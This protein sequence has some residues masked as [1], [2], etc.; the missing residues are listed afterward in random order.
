MKSRM[1]LSPLWKIRSWKKLFLCGKKSLENPTVELPS[2]IIE[3]KVLPRLHATVE[4][5]C[6][7]IESEL[8]RE[9]IEWEILPRLPAQSL[10]RFMRVCKQ[11]KSHI[12]TCDQFT[13]KY[14]QHINKEYLTHHKVL[15][16][17]NLSQTFSTRDCGDLNNHDS[18]IVPQEVLNLANLDGLV[19][20]E[21]VIIREYAFWN[22]LTGAYKKWSNSSKFDS[23]FVAFGLYFD[24]T[25][26]DYKV[27]QW[28]CFNGDFKALIYS[29][30]L[31]STKEIQ[32][33]ENH[34]RLS[35]SDWS[36]LISFGESLYF[37]G[38]SY[39]IGYCNQ[40]SVIVFDVKSEKFREI[41]FPLLNQENPYYY[42]SLM[43]I[44]GC[45]HICV[46]RCRCM[47]MGG[48]LWR[49]DGDGDEE[50]REEVNKIDCSKLAV[51]CRKLAA[52][53]SNLAA[54]K[55]A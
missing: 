8:P 32:L 21:L 19:F 50:E 39:S 44:K 35:N 36:T 5:P 38:K 43:V 14:L 13:R 46:T 47:K 2:E 42:A 49:M 29:Q 54:D 25:E 27:L 41:C 1:L 23:T 16:I 10:C 4:L 7:I 40:F 18:T 28:S 20:P 48:E 53:C 15:E 3:S 12:S 22:P 33:L 30:R 6:E 31:N 17:D 51:A 26:K 37:V 55:H 11:W 9:I 45:I 34:P 24:S 52:A